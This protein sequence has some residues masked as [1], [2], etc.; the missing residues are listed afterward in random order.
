M[1][2]IVILLI[3]NVGG[4]LMDEIRDEEG[5]GHEHVR[6]PLVDRCGVVHGRT[7]RRR[8]W[9]EL[10]GGKLHQTRQEGTDEEDGVTRSC[11][12]HLPG[13][14]TTVAQKSE[15]IN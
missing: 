3:Q 13:Q 9:R 15:R 2:Q 12:A 10:G 7:R 4:P 6:D 14:R 5:D 11:G 1:Y 8:R